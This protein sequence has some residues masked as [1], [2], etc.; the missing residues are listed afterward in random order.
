MVRDHHEKLRAAETEKREIRQ[1]NK[2]GVWGDIRRVFNNTVKNLTFIE[3]TGKTVKSYSMDQSKSNV[4]SG[5]DG[6]QAV[7][8]KRS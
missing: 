2:Q 8:K 6:Y 5:F 3:D 1:K 7:P 4:K